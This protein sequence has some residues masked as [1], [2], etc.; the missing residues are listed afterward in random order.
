[1]ADEHEATEPF[2]VA[3]PSGTVAMLR[4]SADRALEVL[5]VRRAADARDTFSGL[6]V[7]PGGVVDDDDGAFGASELESARMAAVRETLEEAGIVLDPAS[8]LV[9]DRWEPEPRPGPRRRY[10]AWVFLAPATEEGVSIDGS[11]IHDHDWVAPAKAIELHAAG[12]MG[13]AAPTWV[14]LHKLAAHSSVADAL[15]WA[16]NRASDDYRSRLVTIDDELVLLWH[17]DELRDGAA[18]ARHRLW[19]TPGDWRYERST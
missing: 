17:G 5:M 8:L 12:E 16:A 13:I 4:D 18:G 7:F 11:E 14:T 10:S 6:W 3:I 19:M 2:E 1:M 9:L 15:C